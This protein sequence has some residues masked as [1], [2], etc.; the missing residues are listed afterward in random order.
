M[1]PPKK[2][3]GQTPSVPPKKKGSQTP[4]VPPFPVA[5]E[6]ALELH[7]NPKLVQPWAAAEWALRM[8]QWLALESRQ[9]GETVPVQVADLRRPLCTDQF[10][11]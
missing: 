7:P 8:D 3:G 2:K 11:P 6:Q 10:A 1:V 5:A 4:S 9:A